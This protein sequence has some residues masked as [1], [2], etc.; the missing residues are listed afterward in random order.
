MERF[1]YTPCILKISK[2]LGRYWEDISSPLRPGSCVVMGDE[3]HIHPIHGKL[4][5]KRSNNTSADYYLHG[6]GEYTKDVQVYG[7]VAA[8][9]SKV[10]DN[11]LVSLLEDDRVALRLEELKEIASDEM[12]WIAGLS[13]YTWERLASGIED[14]T[15]GFLRSSCL[16]VASSIL[17]F[18]K[19]RVFNVAE[20]LPWSLVRGDRNAKLDA[21]KDGPQP[22]AL[23]PLKIYR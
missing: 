6:A 18:M 15:P 19:H 17:C 3:E 5:L 16:T 14:C 7:T 12:E 23:V 2:I 9:V 8:V 11:L 21:L 22:T 4:L 1:G 10:V 20:E 13:A